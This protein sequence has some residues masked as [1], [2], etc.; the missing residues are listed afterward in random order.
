MPHLTWKYF[1][2]LYPGGKAG[3]TAVL[4]AKEQF[5]VGKFQRDEVVQLCISGPIII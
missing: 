1:P 4:G 5:L 3:I 2:D